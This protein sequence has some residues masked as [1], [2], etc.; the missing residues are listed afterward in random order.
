MSKVLEHLADR[1]NPSVLA[2]A[3][4]VGH[5]AVDY[6][7]YAGGLLLGALLLGYLRRRRD[8]PSIPPI[9]AESSQRGPDAQRGKLEEPGAG[10]SKVQ[11]VAGS[12]PGLVPRPRAFVSYVRENSEEVD[13]IVRFLRSEGVEVW[14]DRSHIKVGERWKDAVRDAIQDGDFF[15]ACFSP[16]YMARGRTYMNVELDIAIEELR[17]RPRDKYW[18]LPVTLGPCTI[19]QIP[20]SGNETLADFQGLDLSD[21]SSIRLQTLADVIL[22]REP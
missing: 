21:Q 3:E 15:I 9:S 1:L 12:P 14:L 17:Q 2:A 16:A 6:L 10:R 18:F 4:S 7:P 20:V 8:L 19:P 5:A 22:A 13:R 11:F